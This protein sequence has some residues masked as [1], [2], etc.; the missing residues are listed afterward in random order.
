MHYILQIIL[1]P[2]ARSLILIRI[3]F[4]FLYMDSF[5]YLIHRHQNTENPKTNP[6]RRTFGV[7]TLFGFLW[8]FQF[9]SILW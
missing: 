1:K 8:F 2:T 7:A 9:F 6:G 5:I 4:G 3:R